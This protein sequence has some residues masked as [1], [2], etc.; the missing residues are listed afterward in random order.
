MMT[1][2]CV[3]FTIYSSFQRWKNFE[4][5]LSFYEGITVSIFGT[6]CILYKRLTFLLLFVGHEHWDVDAFL[7]GNTV[8]P[9]DDWLGVQISTVVVI[10]FFY[11]YHCYHY[12]QKVKVQS[13]RLIMRKSSLRRSDMVRVSYRESHSFTCHPHTYH[14]CR[15]S[16]SH[17]ITALWL[18]LIVPTHG[19]MAR[20]SWPGWLVTYWNRFPAPGV[21]QRGRCGAEFTFTRYF[22]HLENDF[23]GFLDTQNL[24]KDTKFITQRQMQM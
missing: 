1:T 21:K 6:Q 22:F 17:S 4:N 20:L 24:G 10:V 2:I 19:G 3:L 11:N 18:V 8:S 13:E 5:Q 7:D 9:T 23:N 15:Y 14:T 12:Y 16:Q